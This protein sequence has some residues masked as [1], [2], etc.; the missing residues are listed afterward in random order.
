MYEQIGLF[1]PVNPAPRDIRRLQL[2]YLDPV[3]LANMAQAS[4]DALEIT[5]ADGFMTAYFER[6][7]YGSV[8][9]AVVEAIRT[10]ANAMVMFWWDYVKNDL[11]HYYICLTALGRLFIVV[12]VENNNEIVL[13]K[14]RTLVGKNKDTVSTAIHGAARSK[15][16]E[17]IRNDSTPDWDKLVLYQNAV[18][19]FYAS[20]TNDI[21]S[22]IAE[23]TEQDEIEGYVDALIRLATRETLLLVFGRETGKSRVNDLLRLL[24]RRLRDTNPE[25]L[26]R[27]SDAMQ[28][29]TGSDTLKRNMF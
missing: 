23:G 2:L 20:L 27:I 29:M 13:R 17:Y 6:H 9:D 14:M 24:T 18:Y 19:P 5:K 7:G 3:S 16:I 4:P 12:A 10:N 1:D 22:F 11:A 8:V 25:L 15:I 28:G 21:I 26:R